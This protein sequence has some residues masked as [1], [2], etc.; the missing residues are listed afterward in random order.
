[1]YERILAFAF[2]GAF[3][4]PL[5]AGCSSEGCTDIDVAPSYRVTVRDAETNELVCNASVSVDGSDAR[6]ADT[7]SDC[8]YVADIPSGQTASLRVTH[9]DYQPHD[10]QLSTAYETDE[11]DKAIA[12]PVTVKLTRAN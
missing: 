12:V 1:M 3:A 8:T 5:M 11:C 4:S 9:G 6:V 2:A 7:P 10:E